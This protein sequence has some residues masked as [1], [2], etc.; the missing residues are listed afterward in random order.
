MVEGARLES[1]YTSKGYR[2]F[3][4]LSLRLRRCSVLNISFFVFRFTSTYRLKPL[5][6]IEELIKEY[7]H[8][9][10][11]PSAKD[12]GANGVNL[13]ENQGVLLKKIEELTLY[14][15]EQNKR[16][17]LEAQN[18]ELQEIKSS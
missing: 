18:K 12:V 11:V 4:S 6:E 17:I 5:C 3:E 13:G 2:G 10:D 16:E 9:P 14:I 8:L 7:K 1:V 15:I